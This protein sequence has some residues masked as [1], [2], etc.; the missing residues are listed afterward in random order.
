[1]H[2][3]RSGRGCLAPILG[4]ALVIA[5]LAMMGALAPLITTLVQY[6]QILLVGS[7]A[8]VAALLLTPRAG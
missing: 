2:E 1:M 8:T 4:S 3:Q 6:R 7:I 5:L